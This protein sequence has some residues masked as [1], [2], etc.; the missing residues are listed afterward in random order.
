MTCALHT[1]L[2]GPGS[3]V[4][5]VHYVVFLSRIYLALTVPVFTQKYKWE[6][7]GQGDNKKK[8]NAM[9]AS[10]RTSIPYRRV[11]ILRVALYFACRP[12]WSFHKHYKLSILVK[13][14]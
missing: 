6:L 12:G 9:A 2:S 14:L 11:A 7:Q 8:V 3:S 5:R 10:P 1:G 13:R 4:G